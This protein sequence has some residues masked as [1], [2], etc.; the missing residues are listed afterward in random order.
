[1]HMHTEKGG[2]RK[3]DSKRQRKRDTETETQ[4]QR[5]RQSWVDRRG[6]DLGGTWEV[7]IIKTDYMK[8]EN[9]KEWIKCKKK[10]LYHRSNLL[11]KQITL[12]SD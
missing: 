8:L 6:V 1:M 5:Q 12:D 7:S 4:T 10:N 2:Q 11:F 3:R 9:V